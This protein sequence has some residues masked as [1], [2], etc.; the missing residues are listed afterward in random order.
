M[1]KPVVNPGD[2]IQFPLLHNKC[3][4]GLVSTVSSFNTSFL[5]YF[6]S[7]EKNETDGFLTIQERLVPDN[8]ILTSIV[9]DLAV[10]NGR[11]SVIGRLPRSTVNQFA[12]PKFANKYMP[13]RSIQVTN[14]DTLEVEQ[15][16]EVSSNEDLS[17]YVQAGLAGYRALEHEMNRCLKLIGG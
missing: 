16:I 6:F 5:G 3:G 9:S 11:W 15:I 17:D 1:K 10:R 14:P 7:L 4:V 2:V 13:V 8:V 12:F